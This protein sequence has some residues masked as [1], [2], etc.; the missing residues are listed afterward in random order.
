MT[1]VAFI[2]AYVSSRVIKALDIDIFGWFSDRDAINEVCDNFSVLLFHTYLHGLLDGKPFQFVAAQAGSTDNAFYEQLVRI[3]DYVAGTLAD[4][5]MEQDI[6]SKDKFDSML[7]NY[8]AENTHNNFV[9]TLSFKD[10]KFNCGRIS[11][12]KKV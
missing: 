11:I 3:P 6:I 10:D 4:Y 8:M 2:G 7:T 12:Q 9:Y 5:N 1:L